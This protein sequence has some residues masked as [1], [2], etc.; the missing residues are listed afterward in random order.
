VD[1]DWHVEG[2]VE[3]LERWVEIGGG[4]WRVVGDRW[5][6]VEGA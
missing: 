1:S 3:V 5:S 2:C 4:E 6:C